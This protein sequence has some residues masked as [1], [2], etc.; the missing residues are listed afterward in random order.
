MEWASTT[1]NAM[2]VT[3]RRFLLLS[4]LARHILL[5]FAFASVI[6]CRN[7][8]NRGSYETC[9]NHTFL[10]ASALTLGFLRLADIVLIAICPK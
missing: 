9:Y 4:L 2:L 6:L 8:I 1:L 3:C 5:S 7:L 10:F